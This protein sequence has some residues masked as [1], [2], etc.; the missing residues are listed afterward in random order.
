VSAPK[1]F[2]HQDPLD[3]LRR[4]A[5]TPLK[6]HVHL[7]AANVLLETNDLSFFSTLAVVDASGSCSSAQP[8]L[9]KIVRDVAV[10]GKAAEPSIVM[11][12]SLIVFSMGPACLIGADRERREILA[13]IGLEVDARTFQE[14]V[15]PAICRLTEFVMR[16]EEPTELVQPSGVAIGDQCN[17]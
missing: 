14:S 9:W 17:A 16:G 2:S 6:V 13:F 1:I 8:C 7:E 11:A 3:L 15:F 5:P 4:F 12:G 10:H